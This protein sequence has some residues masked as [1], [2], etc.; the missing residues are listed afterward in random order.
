MNDGSCLYPNGL[1]DAKLYYGWTSNGT[2]AWHDPPAVWGTHAP[3][4]KVTTVFGVAVC[5]TAA[6]W[7]ECGR[8]CEHIVHVFYQLLDND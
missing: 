4:R 1:L 5:F 8:R 6:A 7:A 3:C 2:I